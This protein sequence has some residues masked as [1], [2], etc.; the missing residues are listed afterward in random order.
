MFIPIL[1]S[2]AF[3]LASTIF[4]IWMLIDCIR[5]QKLGNKGG[6]IIFII[7][8]QFIGA[9]VYFFTRGPWPR[10]RQYLFQQRS[11]SGYQAPQTP[12]YQPSPAPQSMQE[13][14]SAYERGYQAQQSAPAPIFQEMP[15][16]SALQPEYEQ[17]LLTYPEMPPME[18]QQ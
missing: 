16:P 7:I 8:T 9:A 11:F 5:N 1:F 4:M 18:Q 6:W 17:S 3:S 15:E 10:V 14:F 2:Q 13:E 12:N